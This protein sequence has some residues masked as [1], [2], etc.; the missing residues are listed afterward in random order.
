MKRSV[1]PDFSGSLNSGKTEELEQAMFDSD[2][3][4]RLY[5]LYNIT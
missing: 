5:R 4:E 1:P 2:Q 3:R